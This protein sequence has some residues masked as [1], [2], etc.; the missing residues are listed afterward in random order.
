MASASYRAELTCSVC[1]DIFTDPVSL[2]CGHSFCREC[3]TGSPEQ[4]ACPCCQAVYAA[5]LTTNLTLKKLAN[6]AKE[7][8]RNKVSLNFDMGTELVCVVKIGI[9]PVSTRPT[10]LD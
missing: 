3:V 7:D 2:T 1:Q 5:N 4:R 8:L 9:K 10:L 6:T